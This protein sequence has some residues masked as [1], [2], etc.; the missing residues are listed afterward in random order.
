MD[1]ADAVGQRDDRADVARFS[2]RFEVL[3][4]LPNQLANLGCFDS[5]VSSLEGLADDLLGEPLQARTHRA[6]DYHV[7]RL[8]DRAADQRRVD[9]QRELHCAPELLLE[10]L[11]DLLGDRGVDR[12]SPPSP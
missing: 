6:V 8:D 12:S 1:A 2:L 10:R 11:L 4:A 9:R 5:H 7:V 3:N